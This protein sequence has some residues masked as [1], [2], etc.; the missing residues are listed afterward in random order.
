V[1]CA[2]FDVFKE[3]HSKLKQVKLMAGAVPC[4]FLTGVN[5]QSLSS[6]LSSDFQFGLNSVVDVFFQALGQL[7]SSQT[8]SADG[9][10]VVAELCCLPHAVFYTKLVVRGSQCGCHRKSLSVG[11]ANRSFFLP[12][13]Q[14]AGLPSHRVGTPKFTVALSVQDIVRVHHQWEDKMRLDDFHGGNSGYMHDK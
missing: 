3:C 11:S 6:C 8:A 7:H 5:T 14:G 2:L 4:N 12:G 1:Y 13:E 10:V 9:N